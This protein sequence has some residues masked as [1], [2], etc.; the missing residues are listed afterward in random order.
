VLIPRLSYYIK[1]RD[2]EKIKELIDISYNYVF[3]LSVPIAVGL[4]ALGDDIINIFSGAD[5]ASATVTLR[6]LTPIVIV[7]P[8]SVVTNSQTFVPMG[9]E[10]LILESTFIGAAVNIVCNAVLIPKYAENGAA[11]ATVLA[12]TVIAVICFINIRRFFDMKMVFK[13]YWQYMVAAA[14]ILFIYEVV[15]WIIGN[16]WVRTLLV[17]IISAVIYFAILMA[18][19]NPYI[20]KIVK[21]VV[22]KIKKKSGDGDEDKN[23]DK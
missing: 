2:V 13:V 19:R 10:K 4:F 17:V 8:F 14:P 22:A 20:Y 6:I 23:E 11:V 21:L 3:L 5:F 12:E 18:L 15:K 1:K 16:I 9:E 7:I